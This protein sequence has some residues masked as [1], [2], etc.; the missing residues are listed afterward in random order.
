M[1]VLPNQGESPVRSSSG[2]LGY[3][4]KQAARLLDCSVSTAGKYKNESLRDDSGHVLC[5]V[6]TIDAKRRAKL[7]E[8]GAVEPGSEAASSGTALVSTNKEL[9]ERVQEL[10]ERLRLLAVARA[11]ARDAVRSSLAEEEAY[12]DVAMLDLPPRR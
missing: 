1:S 4:I 5:P 9:T 7:R 11:S 10:E 3:T 2:E 8:L 12:F 6:A